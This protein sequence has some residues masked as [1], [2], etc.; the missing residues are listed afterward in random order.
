MRASK[1]RIP[2]RL[3]IPNNEPASSRVPGGGAARRLET[4]S[5]EERAR[6]GRRGREGERGRARAASSPSNIS[7]LTHGYDSIVRRRRRRDARASFVAT[8]LTR[9]SVCLAEFNRK[10]SRVSFPPILNFPRNVSINVFQVSFLMSIL[11]R[12]KEARKIVL[13]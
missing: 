2:R 11:F 12:V 13:L 9:N 8:A 4:W 1:R 3:L 10:S 7:R 5:S 6:E